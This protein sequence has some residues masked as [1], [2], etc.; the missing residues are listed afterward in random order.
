MLLTGTHRL[1]EGESGHRESHR[2]RDRETQRQRERG[3]ETQEDKQRRLAVLG[4]DE[5]VE[6]PQVWRFRV[7]P[8]PGTSETQRKLCCP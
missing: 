3:G 5:K 2:T 6:G 4:T 1:R 7:C 8:A